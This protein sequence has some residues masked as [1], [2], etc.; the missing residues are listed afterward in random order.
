MV[1]MVPVCLVTWLVLFGLA[2]GGPLQEPAAVAAQL[3]QS[4]K[5]LF[6]RGEYGAAVQRLSEALPIL[7]QNGR[8]EA[9][10]TLALIHQAQANDERALIEFEWALV[11][12]PDLQLDPE[13]YSPKTLALF[14]QAREGGV[15]RFQSAKKN[16]AAGR[17]EQALE[18]FELAASLLQQ[19]DSKR[20]R[21]TVVEALVSSALIYQ[22]LG[23]LSRCLQ[24][25][26]KAVGLQ[27]ELEIDRD[28]Y[29]PST[30]RIF[31]E[32]KEAN[33]RVLTARQAMEKTKRLMAVSLEDLRMQVEDSAE[34]AKA[35]A[36]ETRARTLQSQGELAE[37]DASYQNAASLYQAVIQKWRAEHAA[38]ESL[39]QQY[40]AA[41]EKQDLDAVKRLWPALGSE[42]EQRIGQSFQFVREWRLDLEIT[43]LRISG[44]SAWV[45]C[46]RKDQMVSVDGQK[47]ANE[48]SFTFHL[49]MSDN[50][51]I[52]ESIQD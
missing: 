46:Q 22:T 43:E 8:G 3:L 24:A 38:V 4:G 49:R 39:L 34:S 44:E 40:E 10:L 50:S 41:Y 13:Q 29:S 48:V 6:L 7:D 42:L 23:D 30:L 15:E 27:P 35:A 36:Q 19:S 9:R 47:I 16:F 21:D 28:F 12:A 20:A 14:R 33:Q 5:E 31:D 17:L 18:E 11:E 1:A 51:W 25:F 52:I 45:S 37:S 26:R 2:Y 32:I